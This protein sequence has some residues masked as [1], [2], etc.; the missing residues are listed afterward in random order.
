MLRVDCSV[1]TLG[2]LSVFDGC[3]ASASAYV[4]GVVVC[5]RLT[6]WLCWFINSVVFLFYAC[7][8]VWI[9]GCVNCLFGLLWGCVWSFGVDSGIVTWLL[10]LA[11]VVFIVVGVYWVCGWLVIGCE[12]WL[13]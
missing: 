8:V 10:C 4:V 9:C 2:C 7:G 6:W 12:I 3:F 5:Y 1:L 11:S 13:V